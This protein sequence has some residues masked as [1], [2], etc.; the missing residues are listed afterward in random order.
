VFGTAEGT[1]VSGSRVIAGT[2]TEVS[3]GGDLGVGVDLHL[4]RAVSLGL[5]AGYR[6]MA[7][8]PEP[9]GARDNYSGFTLAVRIGWLF[10]KGSGPSR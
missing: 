2:H 10:G 7:D 5:D 6:W 9:V 1:S 4:G 3:I 8:F